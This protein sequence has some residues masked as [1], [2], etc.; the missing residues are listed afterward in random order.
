MDTPTIQQGSSLF[1]SSIVNNGPSIAGAAS[2]LG[3]VVVAI[4]PE[5]VKSVIRSAA[6]TSFGQSAISFFQ[7]ASPYIGR[8]L[9]YAAPIIGVFIAVAI[10]E[11]TYFACSEYRM[12]H[13]E[14]K[15]SQNPAEKAARTQ[16]MKMDQEVSQNY[17][18]VE[19]QYNSLART[20]EANEHL[21][22]Q[23]LMSKSELATS[24]LGA[25][26][27]VAV[28]IFAGVTVAAA[29]PGAL[30]ASAATL[31]FSLGVRMARKGLYTYRA[32]SA[33]KQM[34]RIIEE[35]RHLLSYRNAKEEVNKVSQINSSQQTTIADLEKRLEKAESDLSN[36]Q[37][38]CKR[39][40]T[41]LQKHQLEIAAC[42]KEIKNEKNNDATVKPL[43]KGD[44]DEDEDKY[45]DAQESLVQPE[46]EPEP[47]HTA[48][49]WWP[50]FL[51]LESVPDDDEITI[52]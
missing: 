3:R 22:N 25:A 27:C 49:G 23:S 21:R 20:K 14:L 24:V 46:P 45:E 6:A 28:P 38:T 10:T 11:S 34:T 13:H 50:S 43:T 44:E 47:E 18:K 7:T 48:T 40:Q 15:D 1:T 42:L 36:E 5:S 2:S 19:Q 12:R 52:F 41:Q 33:D 30:L 35:N 16:A 31:G 39:L 8:A 32:C 51:R 26:V 17:A 9:P 37:A 29:V 4:A